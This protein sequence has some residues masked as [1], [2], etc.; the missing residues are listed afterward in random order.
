MSQIGRVNSTA[1]KVR[2]DWLLLPQ[3]SYANPLEDLIKDIVASK[4]I[5]LTIVLSLGLSYY[6]KQQRYLVDML[7]ISNP[8]SDI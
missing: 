4:I 8:T 7:A 5:L 1:K 2:M 3:N 6:N